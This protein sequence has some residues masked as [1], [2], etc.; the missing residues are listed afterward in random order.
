MR[1][2]HPAF[3]RH[4][5]RT[6]WVI[7]LT[8]TTMVAELIGGAVS[9]SLALLADGWHMAT[10][11]GALG[12]S[13]LAYWFARTRS[14]RP[15]FTFGTG[16]VFALGGYTS[17][18]ILW[19]VALY[20][21]VSAIDRFFHPVAVHF[22]EAFPVA[23]LGLVVNLVSAKL[24]HVHETHDGDR[25][26]H[27]HDAHHSHH[28]HQDPNLRAA[29]LH[30]AADAFTSLLAIAALLGGR[31]FGVPALDP[32]MALVGSVVILHWGFGLL[33]RTGMQLLDACPSPDTA[34]RIRRAVE[35]LPGSRV[36]DLHLWE[37]GPGRRGCIVA[38]ASQP[39]RTVAEIR[40]VVFEVEP[41]EHLTI[42]VE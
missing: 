5:Q 11:A 16:K 19:I 33:R 21:A 2:E 31:Y 36:V 7:A 27:T 6:R 37:L 23:V 10:H 35:A 42:Q 41:I 34:A 4:E 29:Y 39:A 18:V 1:H 25:G 9:H 24:L 3:E 30:V 20:M 28:A 38:V 32:L 40:Q 15:E 22:A 8:V 13:A 12:V 17:A 26:S 14:N